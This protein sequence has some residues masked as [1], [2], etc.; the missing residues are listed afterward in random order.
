MKKENLPL[1]G[2]AEETVAM[3]NMVFVGVK[4]AAVSLPPLPITS[5]NLTFCFTHKKHFLL[6]NCSQT[7]N[8]TTSFSS[9]FS[10][11]SSPLTNKG[12]HVNPKL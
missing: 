3:A 5:K 6:L 8:R 4:V 1:F 12:G 7:N 2:T 11:S 10:F 9:S